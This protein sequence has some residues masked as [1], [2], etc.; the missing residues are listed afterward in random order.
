[1]YCIPNLHHKNIH[2]L[3]IAY[4]TACNA[5][6]QNPEGTYTLRNYNRRS[7]CSISV[8]FPLSVKILATSVGVQ[9]GWPQHTLDYETGLLSKV[10]KLKFLCSRRYFSSKYCFYIKKR[11]FFL[12]WKPGPECILTYFLHFT[13]LLW[14]R[15]RLWT[16]YS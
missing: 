13:K 6:L 9:N 3:I 11:K 5:V 16:S 1:M 8:I 7:N 2:S 10:S 12:T 14:Y 4:S 15:T